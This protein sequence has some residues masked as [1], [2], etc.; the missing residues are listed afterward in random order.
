MV[1]RI[2]AF[3]LLDSSAEMHILV[4]WG[5]FNALTQGYGSNTRVPF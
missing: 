5:Q 1:K 3:V 2:H 4:A